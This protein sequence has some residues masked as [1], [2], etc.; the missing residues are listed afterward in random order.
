MSNEAN[1]ATGT[2]PLHVPA[3]RAEAGYNV[4]GRLV[5][6]P[7]EGFGRLWKREYWA[8]FGTAMPAR[9]VIGQWRAHFGDFWPKGGRFH[10]GLAAISPGDVAPLALGPDHGPKLATGVLVIYADDESF[11]FMTPQGHMFAGLITF[12][13]ADLPGGTEVRISIL[14]RTSDP[15]YELGWPLM[16]SGE[17]RFWPGVL[18]NLAAGVGAGQ[19]EVQTSTECVDRRRQWARWRN[20][21]HNAAIRSA[22]HSVA[23]PF[24]RTR[25]Q[26]G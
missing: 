20:V 22:G 24:R 1:W 17:D 23:A 18:V 4:E 2:G 13:A 15:L 25:E 12:S 21:R 26:A 16:R 6:G 3:D 14:L 8:D 9:T 11:T 7:H 10:G 5:S 19:V